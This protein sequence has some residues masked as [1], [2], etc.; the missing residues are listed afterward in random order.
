MI[1]GLPF[2]LW[3]FCLFLPAMVISF[4]VVRRKHIFPYV[5]VA[6]FSIEYLSPEFL[7]DFFTISKILPIVLLVA[8]LL[9]IKGGLGLRSYRLFKPA[10]ILALYFIVSVLWSPVFMIGVERG[11]SFILLLI[12]FWFVSHFTQ[13]ENGLQHF[14]NAFVFI[15]MIMSFLA[16]ITFLNISSNES[17]IRAGV[18]KLHAIHTSFIITLGTIPLV[19]SFLFRKQKIWKW[20]SVRWHPLIIIMNIIG[21][22]TT[23]TKTSLVVFIICFLS[24]FII[25]TSSFFH[26]RKK[27][28]VSIIVAI[29]FVFAV[30]IYLP[31]IDN[32]IFRLDY[33]NEQQYYLSEPVKYAS[34][35]LLIAGYAL[36]NFLDNPIIGVGLEG[37]K[38]N[39]ILSTAN[40][41]Y[42][43]QTSTHN[44]VLWAL[45]E[46]GIIGTMLWLI[47]ILILLL[48]AIRA[49]RIS[50]YV[51]DV[52]LEEKSV[53]LL[54]MVIAILVSSMSFNIEFNKFFWITLALVESL[55]G[56]SNS[57][58]LA[59]RAWKHHPK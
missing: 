50:R 1:S 39:W 29:V 13:D 51:K 5:Y 25:H 46:G 42:Q 11:L 54:I 58:S 26:L 32:F 37:F 16:I 6:I 28:I 36:A 45:A 12:S 21:I 55:W 14:I 4:W 43:F 33:M 10:L 41:N 35:R 34:G 8:Y 30:N 57:K 48:S 38:E 59:V 19:V 22:L 24:L 53:C 3:A 20:L 17:F 44:S 56:L 2:W 40:T 31:I 15:S 7:G 23:A 9:S 49:T 52:V 47:L 27:I 18:F